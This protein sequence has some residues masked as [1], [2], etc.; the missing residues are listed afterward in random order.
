M[1]EDNPRE[2]LAPPPDKRA[3]ARVPILLAVSGVV[4]ATALGTVAT[5]SAAPK[6]TSGQSPNTGRVQVNPY[7][8]QTVG[9][10]QTPA[11]SPT[12]PQGSTSQTT[13]P[14]ST[15]APTTTHRAK[16]T[17]TSGPHGFTTVTIPDTT[18]PPP[19]PPPTTTTPPPPTTTPPPPPPTTTPQPPTT[20]PKPAGS[21]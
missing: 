12:P 20:T 9:T 1:D 18:T 11:G 5:I 4:L 6:T 2:Q 15:T 10:S 7:T 8:G 14:N 3:S 13:A 19:P 16:V 17:T 21:R